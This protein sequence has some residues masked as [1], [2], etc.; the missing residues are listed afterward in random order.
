MVILLRFEDRFTE[1]AKHA[2]ELAQTAAVELGHNYVGSEHIL[3]GLSREGG[4]VAAKILRESGIESQI[5]FDLIV[6]N[7]GR[8]PHGEAQVQGLTP[9]AKHIIET[10]V[11]EANRLGH[12]YVSTEHLLLGILREYDSVAAKLILVTGAD[13][14]KL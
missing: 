10:A 5:I 6:K 9:N 3:L 8:G 2:F 4:G 14:N 7:V 12:G 11:V 1:R 13:L